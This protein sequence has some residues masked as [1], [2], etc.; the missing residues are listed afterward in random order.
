MP[1]CPKCKYEYRPGIDICPD[2]GERLVYSLPEEALSDEPDIYSGYSEWLP[3]ARL[4]SA[5]LAGMVVEGLKAKEIP[6]VLLSESGY[7]GHMGLSA[8]RT[9]PLGGGHLIMVPAQF[10]GDADMEAK[11][12]LGD[13]WVRWRLE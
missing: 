7:L 10:A 13:E 3:L 9:N 2:C 12:M 6:A 8:G 1:Y 11:L 5:Q 4:A